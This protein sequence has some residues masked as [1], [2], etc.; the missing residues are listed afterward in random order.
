MFTRNRRLLPT[1]A[2]FTLIELLVVIAIIAI[3]AAILFPVFAQARE[4]AR[5][6][7]CLSNQKQLGLGLMMYAQDY[8]ERL[9]R[10]SWDCGTWSGVPSLTWMDQV[11]PYVKSTKLFKCPNYDGYPG[12]DWGL[13]CASPYVKDLKEYQMGYGLNALILMG[14]LKG[15]DTYALAELDRP[16]EIGMI[17]DGYG[18]DA[19]YIGYCLDLGE[20]YHR[21]WLHSDQ[22]S[23]TYGPARH[24][25]GG[26]FVFGDG[27]AKWAKATITK[28]SDVFWGYF[29][30]RVDPDQA[31]CK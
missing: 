2:A 10:M 18:P 14:Y 30:V 17:G 21:Y 8:D 24:T 25:E 4:K 11:Y 7:T 6:I 3:L 28:E 5:T 22:K 16:A 13:S 27:H 15:N 29:K 19:T 12:W 31:T 20:G 9:L 23:W 1:R 26:N